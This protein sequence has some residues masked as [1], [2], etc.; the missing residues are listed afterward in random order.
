MTY[1]NLSGAAVAN[2]HS[3]R[4]LI[5]S[6]CGKTVDVPL[7]CGDRFCPVCSGPRR[8]RMARRIGQLVA[9][10][11]TKRGERWRFITLTIPNTKTPEAGL[12]VL[13][14]AFRRLR[15]RKAWKR[16][17]RGG[18]YAAEV[19]RSDSGWHVHLHCLAVGIFFPQHELARLWKSCS[20][21]RIVDIRKIPTAAAAAYLTKYVTKT[22]LAPADRAAASAAY[23]SRRLYSFFG[24]CHSVKIPKEHHPYACECGACGCYLPMSLLD[25]QREYDWSADARAAPAPAAARP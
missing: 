25:Y 7:F 22:T 19:T 5:C 9:R 16:Y 24:D 14:R 8:A 12:D 4:R 13:F 1:P 20:P 17:V 23:R 15:Q 3:F 21:G 2:S 18:V 6:N 11:P 10:M